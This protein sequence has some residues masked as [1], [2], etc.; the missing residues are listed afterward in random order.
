MNNNIRINKYLSLCGLGARRKVEEYILNGEIKINGKIIKLLSVTVDPDKDTVEYNNSIIKVQNKKYFIII[1]K[2]KGYVTTV[3]D[4]QGRP[5]VMELIPERFRAAMV[6][7]VG[8]LDMN[9]EGLL[10]LTNEG[11][12]AYKLAHPKFGIKKEYLVEI[13]KQLLDADRIKIEKG[14]FLYGEMTR[15]AKIEI[16]NKERN[17]IKMTISE[18]KKR[19]IRMSFDKFSYKVRKLKRISFGPIK[20]G[21][22]YTGSYRQLKKDEIKKLCSAVGIKNILA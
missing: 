18:G 22:L 13:D 10:L 20:L 15:P 17:F 7:P 12:I 9:S 5:T 16:L 3:K 6:S 11:D 14:I 19:H 21:N 4:E 1:N 2:P 8:R